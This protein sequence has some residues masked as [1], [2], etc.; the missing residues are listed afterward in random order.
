[1]DRAIH[2]P[3]VDARLCLLAVGENRLTPEIGPPFEGPLQTQTSMLQG[4]QLPFCLCSP[5][6][7]VSLITL[8][9][10][11]RAADAW[12]TSLPAASAVCRQTL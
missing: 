6:S 9:T 1:M 4:F 12:M 5:S 7:I 2:L 8:S 10:P 11:T 3:P